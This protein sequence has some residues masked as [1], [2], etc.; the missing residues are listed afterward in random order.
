MSYTWVFGQGQ[1]SGS[2]VKTTHDFKAAGNYTV[3]LIVKDDRGAT[4]SAQR[5]VNFN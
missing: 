4:S 3:T 1:G 5:S 2:G